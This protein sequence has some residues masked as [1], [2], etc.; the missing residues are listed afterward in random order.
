MS[1]IEYQ[2]SSEQLKS[3]SQNYLEQGQRQGYFVL[4]GQGIKYLPSGQRYDFSAPKERVRARFYF[5]LIEKYQ[6]PPERIE[7]A[8]VVPD[9]IPERYADIVVYKDSSRQIPYM[10]IECRS[11]GIKAAEFKKAVVQAV[12]KAKILEA[13]LAVCVA[14]QK[15]K[16][17]KIEK[18]AE[19]IIKNLPVFYEKL[20]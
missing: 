3:E 18:Q 6:Y 2:K 17:I 12:I 4:D 11:A 13:K 8:V 19:K 7:F 5:D 9:Q 1:E 14:G 20:N 15:Q 16:I 10:V